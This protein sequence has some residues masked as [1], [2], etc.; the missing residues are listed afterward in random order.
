MQLLPSEF[1]HCTGSYG[2]DKESSQMKHSDH[3]LL[4]SKL[5]SH[6]HSG[7]RDFF[8]TDVG[9]VLKEI[10]T[11]LQKRKGPRGGVLQPFPVRLYSMLE[12]AEEDNQEDI[13]S[14]QPHGRCFLV[15]DPKRFCEKVL[16]K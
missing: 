1:M 11:P 4:V 12:T 2:D 9:T 5:S 13:V 3:A 14:W 7:Y 10:A 6:S 15:R 8:T 16:H